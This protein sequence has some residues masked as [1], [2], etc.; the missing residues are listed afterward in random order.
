MGEKFRQFISIVMMVSLLISGTSYSVFADGEQSRPSVSEALEQRQIDFNEGWKFHLDE[1]D[2]GNA[3]RPDFDDQKWQ[4]LDLPH[5]WSIYFDFNHNSPALNE[6]GLLDGGTAWYRKQFSLPTGFDNKQVRIYFGGVY[7]NSSLYVNGRL[8]GNYPNGYTPFSYDITPYLYKNGKINTLAMKVVNKQPSSRWY[9]GSG[10][11]RDVSLMVTDKLHIQQYGTTV[12]T[13]NLAQQVGAMVDTA[14]KTKLEN[15]YETDKKVSLKYTIFDNQTQTVVAEKMGATHTISAGTALEITDSVAVN[16]PTLWTTEVD[17]V[18][19]KAATYSLRT[20]VLMDGQMV[21]SEQVR[22]GYRYMDWTGSDG[23]FLNGQWMKLHG[24]CMHHDQGALGAVANPN[25]IYRQ[26][27]MMKEMGVNAIRSTHNPADKALIEACEDLGL[28][29]I[30]EAFD[31]WYAGKK[32]YDYHNYFNEPATHPEAKVGQVWSEY[33]LKEM[34]KRGKNS[35]SIIMWSIGN[36]I[37]ESGFGDSKSVQTAK[38]LTKWIKEV[39]DTRYV[40]MGQDVYRFVTFGPHE[41]V[42][43]PLDAVGFNYAEFNYHKLRGKHPEWRIYGSETASAISS[44]GIYYYP[45]KIIK[46]DDG[47]DRKYQQSD[48]LNDH[49]M[50]GRTGTNAWIPDRDNKGYAG[51][52]IWTGFDYI[53]EPTPW[54]GQNSKPPKSSYFGVVDTAG[55]PK[56]GFYFYQSQWLEL[57]KQPMVHI[58]PHWNWEDP[59]LLASQGTVLGTF[60]K[61]IPVR[62]YSNAPKVE[63]FLNDRSLGMKS[64][65]QKKTDYGLAYQEGILP[66]RLYLEWR[67]DFTPG[68]LKAIAYDKDGNV[69]AEDVVR[70]AGQAAQVSLRPEKK[71]IRADGRDLSYIHVDITDENGVI[72][73]TATNEVV[74]SIRGDGKIVGVDNGNP[75]SNERYKAQHD[76][77][78]K[79]RAFSGKALLIVESTK[80]NGSFEVTARADGLAQDSTRIYTVAE[81]TPSDQIIGYDIPRMVIHKGQEI[82]LPEKVKSVAADGSQQLVEVV[83]QAYDPNLVN[84][85]GEFVIEGQ[86]GAAV[87]RQRVIV[88]GLVGAKSISLSTPIEVM[89]SLPRT[90]QVYYS[91]GNFVEGE[92]IWEPIATEQLNRIHTFTTPGMIVIDNVAY[93]ITASIEVTDNVSSFNIAP[94]AV[95]LIESEAKGDNLKAMNDGQIGGLLKKQRW[96]NWNDGHSTEGGYVG[97]TWDKV[98]KISDVGLYFFTDIDVRLPEQVTMEYHNPETGQ[99]Q[100]VK[101]MHHDDFSFI[102]WHEN[103]ISFDKVVTDGIRVKMQAQPNRF[104]GLTEVKVY[105]DFAREQTTAMLQSIRLDQQP[106]ADFVPDKYIYYY[107]LEYAAAV[108]QVTATSFDNAGVLVI[109]SIVKEDPTKITVTSEDG[110]TTRTYTIHWE[111]K[112]ALVSQA[113]L[114]VDS[115]VVQADQVLDLVVSAKLENGLPVYPNDM[116]VEYVIENNQQNVRIEKDQLLALKP[117]NISLSA[118][119]TYK[120]KQYPTNR[121]DITIEP[122]NVNSNIIGFKEVEVITERQVVPELPTKVMAYYDNQGLPKEVAVEWEPITAQALNYYETVEL[123]G[124]VVGCPIRPLLRIKVVGVRGVENISLAT[125]VREIPELPERVKVY[126]SDGNVAEKAVQWETI[127]AEDVLTEGIRSYYGQVEGVDLPAKLTVRV[128]SATKNGNNVAKMW[129]GAVIPAG[130][131]SY[132]CDTWLSADKVSYLNDAQISYDNKNKNRWTNYSFP[133]R[134]T[135]WAGILFGKSGEMSQR[136]IDNIHVMLFKDHATAKPESYRIEYYLPAED[137]ELAA[138]LGQFDKAT[139]N[140]LSDPNNWREVNYIRKPE[141]S[142]E[143]GN[144]NSIY[145]ETVRTHAIRIV[146]I[147]QKLKTA[148]GITEIE[149]YDTIPVLRESYQLQVRIDG[150]PIAINAEQNDYQYTNSQDRIPLIEVFDSSGNNPK[151]DLILPNRP[152]GTIKIM[153]AAEDGTNRRTITIRLQ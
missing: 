11:Y 41:E 4:E 34:V 75:A 38:N 30:E 36:E 44:R 108:P 102:L 138:E 81:G 21:D 80:H 132:T 128:T 67:L 8:V 152:Q 119:V 13:P 22:F 116:M 49:V 112:D 5:D 62:I 39:D 82:V 53:G 50:W 79:R 106:L 140:P 12:T 100:P 56:N 59:E 48:Y 66:D 15:D 78:W 146:V 27:V 135:D 137:P 6:G 122:N 72:V 145:F 129:T 57:E 151:I 46:H 153:V 52:F 90:G 77:S 96:T 31:T 123:A 111:V 101:S 88:H 17:G 139:A 86:A 32:A 29:L 113:I 121:L 73:P 47:A 150:Q 71:V 25:A 40:T 7:M 92:I 64:F 70:S 127:A 104:V 19:Q 68:V 126:Y 125:P 84:Q 24:V 149:V 136:D 74:F 99:W 18:N 124:T 23:F 130:I 37:W 89:P 2:L 95:T 61:K 142:D 91:D 42:S 107:P 115:L 117:G 85:I 1:G 109:N 54:Y 76:G 93:P 83:W 120:N 105:A 45:D 9:S 20:E 133:K 118:V 69:V 114:S 35:P 147:P 134:E 110:Q 87:V 60:D 148:V 55:F 141:L 28:L 43:V 143:K 16:Q 14:I 97:M 33:D 103:K 131:A 144:V 98:Y 58:M 63:L 10:I 65:I 51:Q 26:M 94:N 3:Y